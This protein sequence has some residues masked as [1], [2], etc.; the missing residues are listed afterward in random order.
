[1][2]ITNGLG[3]D[4]DFA[5]AMASHGEGT[6]KVTIDGDKETHDAQRV[7]RNGRGSF[8]EIFANVVRVAE[9]CPEVKLR[10]GGNFKPEQVAS[11]E[12]LLDRLEGA[13]LR[14]KLESIAFKP[15]I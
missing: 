12:R 6:I 11:Y 10:V 7:Y 5:R 8:D 3:L 13:G 4:L 15:I 2:I 1:Q 9:E 14:G